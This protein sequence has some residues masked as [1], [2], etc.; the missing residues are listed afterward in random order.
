M[1]NDIDEGSD[2]TQYQKDNE[3][4][5]LYEEYNRTV[6]TLETKEIEI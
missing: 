3:I 1:Q 6:I 2:N 5:V 4:A